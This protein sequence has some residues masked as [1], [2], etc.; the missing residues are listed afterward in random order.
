MWVYERK[1]A[2]SKVTKRCL[3]IYC[4]QLKDLKFLQPTFFYPKIV[5]FFS[6]LNLASWRLLFVAR[7]SDSIKFLMDEN[8]ICFLVHRSSSV[9]QSRETGL[10]E[11]VSIDASDEMSLFNGEREQFVRF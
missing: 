3:P 1:L 2:Q 5:F 7:L 10:P 9:G 11:T 6:Q 4:K 8:E